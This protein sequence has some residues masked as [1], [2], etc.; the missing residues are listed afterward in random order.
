MLTNIN[1]EIIS[2]DSMQIYKEMSIGSSKPTEEERK[3][4]LHHLVDFVDVDKRY[5][6]A[7]YKEDCQ[8]AIEDIL[9]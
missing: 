5:S 2:A 4:A 3:Q 8:K 6:V 9:I 7:E 1:G